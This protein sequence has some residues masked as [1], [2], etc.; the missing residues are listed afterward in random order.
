MY[1]AAHDVISHISFKI[2]TAQFVSGFNKV[3]DTMKIK[4]FTHFDDNKDE[5]SFFDQ[6]VFIMWKQWNNIETQQQAGKYC[7]WNMSDERER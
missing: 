2:I 5:N 3:T 6:H 4:S 7:C 1:L